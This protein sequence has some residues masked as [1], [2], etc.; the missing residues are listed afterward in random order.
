MTGKQDRHH[1]FGRVSMFA[2]RISRL[3]REKRFKDGSDQQQS[4]EPI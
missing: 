1:S 2:I 3:P 4:V